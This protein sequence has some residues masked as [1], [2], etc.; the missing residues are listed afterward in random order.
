MSFVDTGSYLGQPL[1][2]GRAYDTINS[3][4]G[5]LGRLD[6]LG[7]IE[8]GLDSSVSA[9]DPLG[10]RLRLVQ[11][12]ISQISMHLPGGFATGLNRQF[13]NLMDEDAWQDEDDLVSP[14]ALTAFTHVLLSTETRR[15]PGIGTNGRG[16][17]T[18]S[19]TSG[20]NRLT[21]ECLPSKRVSMTLSRHRNDGDVERAAFDAVTPER[22]RELLLPFNPEVWF[23]I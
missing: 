9:L 16:S 5:S 10:N 12:R 17:I 19:W 21:I 18:A 6:G 13:A 15:R 2:S 8:A 11:N 14:D 1:T 20:G 22:V 3:L 4:L 7:R 23:D